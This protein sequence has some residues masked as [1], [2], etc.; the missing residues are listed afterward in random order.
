VFSFRTTTRRIEIYAIGALIAACGWP[1]IM[2]RCK[3]TFARVTARKLRVCQADKAL[4]RLRENDELNC[5]LVGIARIC[6]RWIRPL[7]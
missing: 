4:F 6:G 3:P 1:A 7:F 2:I 5:A